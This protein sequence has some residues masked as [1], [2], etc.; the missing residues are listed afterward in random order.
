MK[1]FL[2]ILRKSLLFR[3]IAEDEIETML[4]CLSAWVSDYEKGAYLLRPG[5]AVTAVG[6]IV[7]GSVEIV[8]EDFWGNRNILA[9]FGPGQLFAESY[10]CSPQVTLDL[11][12][13]AETPCRVLFLDVQR[14]LTTCTS[15]C[16]FHAIDPQ[17]PGRIG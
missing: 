14:V 16:V 12:V 15:A 3:G 10:A 9:K 5:E 17:P 7:K 6:L 1:I 8:K 4:Q 2:S 13:L 11:G